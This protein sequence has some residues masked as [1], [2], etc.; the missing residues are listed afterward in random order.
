MSFSSRV[1]P[2]GQND[3]HG[4]RHPIEANDE[5]FSAKDVTLLTSK[6]KSLQIKVL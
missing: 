4:S 6:T 3:L 2:L 1:I 5:P